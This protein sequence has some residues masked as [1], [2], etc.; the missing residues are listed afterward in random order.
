MDAAY[1]IVTP[2]LELYALSLADIDALI[3][4]E[5]MKL[6]ERLQAT[7]PLAWPG[8]QLTSALPTIA[9]AMKEEPGDARWVWIVIER[10]T[11][12]VIGDIGYH[13]PLRNGATAEIGYVLVPAAQ[14]RGYATEATA[15]LITWTFTQTHVARIIAQI[16]S[17]N[18]ASVRVAVK[19]GMQ[20]RPPVSQEYLCYG[21]ERPPGES[22]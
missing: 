21:I 11:A 19:V 1:T 17:T 8:P 14:G 5:R 4:A 2:R 7:L 6:E 13:G 15:A 20:A 16:A 22:A 18:A 3:R 12:S 9:E 10:S